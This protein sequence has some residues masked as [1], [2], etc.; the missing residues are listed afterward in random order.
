MRDVLQEQMKIRAARVTS[1]G[2]GKAALE[3]MRDNMTWAVAVADLM[4]VRWKRA[5]EEHETAAAADWLN[6]AVKW[7]EY[8]LKCAKAIAPYEAAKLAAVA[9]AR[10]QPLGERAQTIG[11]G[12]L[13]HIKERF[14]KEV[15][16]SQKPKESSH[17]DSI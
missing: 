16:D 17:A 2:K 12:R 1:A 3:V 14:T 4:T 6:E 9:P 15:Q 8:A 7:R 13:A 10:Q 11:A 5:A